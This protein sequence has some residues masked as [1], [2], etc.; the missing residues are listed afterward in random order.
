MKKII[1]LNLFIVLI[2][3]SCKPESKP[4]ENNPIADANIWAEQIEANTSLVK[5]EGWAEEDWKAVNKNVDQEKIFNTIVNAVI[6]GKAKAYDFFTDSVFT[7]DQV[8]ERLGSDIKA[9]NISSIRTREKWNFNED[10]FKLEKQVTRIYLFTPKLD[11]NGD[12][13]GDKALFYVKLDN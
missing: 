12:I 13:L 2:L 4:V 7:V 3:S 5:P 8:K 11:E 6:S 1:F 9:G 10:D